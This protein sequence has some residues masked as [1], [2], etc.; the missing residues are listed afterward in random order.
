MEV[1]PELLQKYYKGICSELEK[2]IVEEWLESQESRT[3]YPGQSRLNEIEKEMWE[4]ISTGMDG[5]QATTI[6]LHK[7]V[8]RYA[9]A[10]IILFTVG[11]F[12][13]QALLDN[14]YGT[15]RTER[16]ITLKTIK[17]Q[18]G[19]KRTV[20]LPDGS[21]VR[22]N[23]ETEIKAP[24]KFVGNERVVYLSGHAHF[25]IVRN[26]GKPFIIYTEDSKTQVLGTS[27]DINTKEKGET[28]IIVTSGKVAFSQKDN[29][30]NLV[31]LEVND[32]ALL[33]ANKSIATNV[34]NAQQL[35][36]WRKDQL[37]FEGET[38]KEIIDVL[39]PWYDV[40]ITVEDQDLLDDTYRL[41]KDNPSLERVLMQLSFVGRFEY[42][43]E[44]QN[45]TIF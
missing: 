8:M 5:E 29:A 23:Y 3:T 14:P 31:T 28:E 6:P 41:F 17:T 10:V 45:V 30:D 36:A 12:T 21:T 35:T 26:H 9:A 13:Y 40:K 1:T 2:K 4:N 44:G 22:M 34:V 15:T 42:R 20:T 32:R 24:G 25:D 43:I 37:V 11:F 16:S 27:F 7:R 33:S 19:E 39:E 38:L 18:R